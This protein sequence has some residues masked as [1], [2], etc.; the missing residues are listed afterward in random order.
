MITVSTTLRGLS[1]FHIKFGIDKAHL[2]RI[3]HS[4]PDS[5]LSKL[6]TDLELSIISINPVK[7]QT[8]DES[9]EIIRLSECHYLL[10][11]PDDI[12]IYGSRHKITVDVSILLNTLASE[13]KWHLS[14]LD[15]IVSKAP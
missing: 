12:D 5:G 7:F 14:Y 13:I 6:R 4:Y 1:A 3:V 9:L 15:Q 11:I 10:T 8:P 2:L